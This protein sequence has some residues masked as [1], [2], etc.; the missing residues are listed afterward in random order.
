MTTSSYDNTLIELFESRWESI[1]RLQSLSSPCQYA[2]WLA[3][4][5]HL[6]HK[7]MELIPDESLLSFI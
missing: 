4:I 6:V 7:N 3:A 5:S 2:C 1:K